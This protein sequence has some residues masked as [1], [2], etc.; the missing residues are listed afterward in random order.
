MTEPIPPGRAGRLWLL[1][2]LSS[3]RRSLELLDRKRQLLLREHD[4]L[5]TLRAEN[6]RLWTASCAE[7]ERW[8]LLATV[9]GGASDVGLAAAAVAGQATVEITWRNTMGVRHPDELRGVFVT[10]PPASSAAANTAVAPAAAAYRHA[11]EAAVAHAETDA[12]WRLVDAELHANDRRLRAIERH[13]LP[14][15]EDAL[16]RLQLR[17]DELEQEERVVT[18]WA[19][20]RRQGQ[21]AGPAVPTDDDAPAAS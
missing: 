19:Q 5:A 14:V 15:L 9:L 10:L 8:G 21:L 1:G 18:R 6:L 11:L 4:R 12:S 3:A 16:R 20:R 7:A 2:R 17:L 13:R